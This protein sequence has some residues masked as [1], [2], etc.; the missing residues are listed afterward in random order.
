[1]EITINNQKLKTKNKSPFHEQKNVEICSVCFMLGHHRCSA[2]GEIVYQHDIVIV[3]VDGSKSK[4]NTQHLSLLCKLFLKSKTVYFDTSEFLFY[5][6][7]HNNDFIGYFSKEKKSI[8]NYILSCILVLPPFQQQGY[9]RKMIEFAYEL[10]RMNQ[11][12]GG[13][14]EPLSMLGLKAFFNYWR[15]V[16]L[17]ILVNNNLTLTISELSAI[18]G[19]RQSDIV[20]TLFKMG[21]LSHCDS[22]TC[23][24]AKEKVETY[25]ARHRISLNRTIQVKKIRFWFA[26][27]C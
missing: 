16:L 24:I 10:A 26:I 17:D 6:F 20:Y 8:E 7:Y 13:P 2:I 15:I 3:Q 19:F 18:T 12:V 27:Q 23:S 4:R 9:G 11:I 22:N 25:I 14:E 1:M 21:F 5:L